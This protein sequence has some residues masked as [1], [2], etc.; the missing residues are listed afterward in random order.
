MFRGLSAAIC[1]TTTAKQ[2]P[3]ILRTEDIEDCGI[4]DTKT[5]PALAR[6]AG[7]LVRTQVHFERTDVHNLWIVGIVAQGA[8][9]RRVF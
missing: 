6:A 9:P 7:G 5:P 3:G 2:E 1:N 8:G 4:Y